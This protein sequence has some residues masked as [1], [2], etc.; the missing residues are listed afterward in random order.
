MNPIK[1][2]K[3]NGIK[4]T[5]SVIWEFKLDFI[6][7]KILLL[8]L[9][10]KQ[11]KNIIVIESHN[12]FD[13]NGG[14][15][16]D[17]LIEH[18]F[19]EHY[20]IVWLVKNS[21]KH[22][23]PKNVKCFKIHQPGIT[24]NYYICRAKIFT[25]DCEV[26]GKV[27]EGQKSYY[28]SH[29]AFS[30]KNSSGKI[31]IPSRVDYIL[32]PSESVRD[33]Q[34]KQYRPEKNTELIVLGFPV[35]DKLLMECIPQLKKI[36]I[37]HYNKVIIWMPTFRK[38]G[39]FKRN[40][41]LGELPLGIPLITSNEKLTELSEF[42]KKENVLLIIKIHPMQDISTVKIMESENICLL[43]G[44]RI[45]ECGIDNYE[46]LK[47]TDALISDYSSISYDYLFLNKPIGYIFSDLEELKNGLITDVA[48]DF[49]AGPIINT[50]EEFTKFI[51][52]V[53]TSNDFHTVRRQNL[54]K[55]IFKNQDGN[56]CKLIT[57]HMD[58]ISGK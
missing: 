39:G 30:L 50:Y 20:L 49:I 57:E 11:L 35:H 36:S 2:I 34:M 46:L 18:Q 54:L 58:L 10:N 13:S 27:R 8:F 23:L 24:K 33:I 9:N 52:G 26:T 42:L 3:S 37:K 17:Y 4:H 28:F 7:R 16:Y 40:D 31:D 51:W 55:K 14:A 48:E 1:Y 56:S 19:N 21:I 44:K 22:N 25:A 45:K 41:S 47:Q 29:G 53:V 12:D 15:F 5:L 43:T 6:I 32:I 38:G